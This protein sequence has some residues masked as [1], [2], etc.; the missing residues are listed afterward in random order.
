MSE[1]EPSGPCGNCVG[2]C[3]RQSII[4]PLKKEEADTLRAV[5][6]SLKELLPAGEEVNW[7]SR[8]YFKKNVPSDRRFLRSKAKALEPGQGYYGLESD[9]GFL[10]T[11]ESGASI[12][13]VHDNDEL[14]PEICG[15][16]KAGSIA[17]REIRKGTL[18]RM[19]R[20]DSLI[21]SLAGVALGEE[22]I[23]TF[24]DA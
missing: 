1:A 21:P 12:C 19:Y 4:L 11:T 13:S 17:C 8:R 3:C 14:R 22:T 24:E 16:F 9:C 5:G 18:A 10:E 6:T 7:S 2:A 23:R 15:E 20:E